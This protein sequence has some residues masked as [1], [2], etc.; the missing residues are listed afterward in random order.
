LSFII[1][2]AKDQR[3]VTSSGL[4]PRTLDGRIREVV[5]E[6]FGSHDVE[7][8]GRVPSRIAW[9]RDHLHPLAV[10]EPLSDDR[11]PRLSVENGDDVRNGGD[12]PPVDEGDKD[13]VLKLEP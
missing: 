10:A 2:I 9:K 4:D 12:D 6:R 7:P 13:L 1:S 8:A 5:V 3:P 11:L